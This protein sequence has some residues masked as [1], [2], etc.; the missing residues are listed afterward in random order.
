MEFVEL[1]GL[2]LERQCLEVS[3]FRH[4]A[5]MVLVVARGG[6]GGRLRVVGAVLEDVRHERGRPR[7]MRARGVGVVHGGVHVGVRDTGAVYAVEGSEGLVLRRGCGGARG[8]ERVAVSQDFGSFLAGKDRRG[9]EVEA[10][11]RQFPLLAALHGC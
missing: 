6:R 3:L 4:H 8:E 11:A 10:R 5:E 2:V 7:T 9:R 1:Q